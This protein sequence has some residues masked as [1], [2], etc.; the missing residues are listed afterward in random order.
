MNNDMT[1]EDKIKLFNDIKSQFCS[2]M[3]V[4]RID[5]Y[6]Y[7]EDDSCFIRLRWVTADDDGI[8]INKQI[9]DDDHF[10]TWDNVKTI[11]IDHK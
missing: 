3:F 2:D 5:F 4:I 11:E 6:Y 8:Y 10:I 7:G 9:K 1:K